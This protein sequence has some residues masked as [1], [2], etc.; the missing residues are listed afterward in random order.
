MSDRVK[1]DLITGQVVVDDRPKY[2]NL[3]IRFV[4]V[5][6]EVEDGGNKFGK[7]VLPFKGKIVAVNAVVDEPGDDGDLSIEF[8]KNFGAGILDQPI[9]I[10]E[11]EE[12]DDG[13]H[14][15]TDPDF[16]AGDILTVNI[17][18]PVNGAKGLLL[19]FKFRKIK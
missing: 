7:I 3:E 18:A 13:E 15:I 8:A 10:L 19:L 4:A 1:F 2:L 16:D 9:T 17:N 14:E 12:E 6:K 5:D 11:G